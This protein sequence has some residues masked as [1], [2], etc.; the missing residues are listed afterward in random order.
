MIFVLKA[1]KLD[2]ET[3]IQIENMLCGIDEVYNSLLITYYHALL[4]ISYK[5]GILLEFRL[6]CPYKQTIPFTLKSSLT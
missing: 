2:I 6:K 3:N 5:H 4:Y 1:N